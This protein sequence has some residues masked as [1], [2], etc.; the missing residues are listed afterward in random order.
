MKDAV[1]V[2]LHVLASARSG[3][4][5]DKINIGVFA[6]GE[7]AYRAIRAQ[8]TPE[9]VAAHFQGMPFSAIA[10][11]RVDNLLALNIV[12]SGAIPGGAS[13]TLRLDNMGKT[14]ASALQRMCIVS[15]GDS[16]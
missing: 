16:I 11:H 14:I 15:P 12:I 4:K 13:N 10:V 2:P 9:A 6:H 3:D 7:A 1:K 8:L 5:G